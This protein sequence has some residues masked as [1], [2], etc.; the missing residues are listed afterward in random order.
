[1]KQY[2]VKIKTKN[3]GKQTFIIL[4]S[5]SAAV[6]RLILRST[7]RDDEIRYIAVRKI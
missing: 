4:G 5:S 1:M 6:V 2:R 3:R 7:D